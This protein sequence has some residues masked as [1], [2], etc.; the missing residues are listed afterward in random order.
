M[1][2][3]ETRR[4]DLGTDNSPTLI[5]ENK[6]KRRAKGG[7][8]NPKI[9]RNP[10]LE[11]SSTTTIAAKKGTSNGIVKLGRTEIRKIREVKT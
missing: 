8:G 7:Q 6:G 2:N 4:K 1:F 5:T 3:E 10:S 9:D 11:E